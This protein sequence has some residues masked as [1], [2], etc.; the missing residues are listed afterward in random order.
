[1]SNE[2]E[3]IRVYRGEAI[4]VIDDLTTVQELLSL[5]NI[6][7]F[8]SYDITKALGTKLGFGS[9]NNALPAGSMPLGQAV[10]TIKTK[11]NKIKAKYI[12][13]F[14]EELAPLS[15]SKL[16]SFKCLPTAGLLNNM[17]LV[18]GVSK[19]LE[20]MKQKQDSINSKIDEMNKKAN[21]TQLNGSALS[22]FYTIANARILDSY[23]KEQQLVDDFTRKQKEKADKVKN[24]Y[25]RYVEATLNNMPMDSSVPLG[26]NTI[27]LGLT[28]VPVDPV[29]SALANF[30]MFLL[31]CQA[32]KSTQLCSNKN[33]PLTRE[34]LTSSRV[35]GASLS[36]DASNAASN[37]KS[38][39]IEGAVELQSPSFKA[40]EARFNHA[41]SFGFR[42][43]GKRS[44]YQ[45]QYASI[46]RSIGNSRSV[47][48]VEA[49]VNEIEKLI[50]RIEAS[51]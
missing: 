36:N 30:N 26:L 24:D 38:K 13:T 2:R 3:A 31:S 34:S 46:I 35:T 5:Y 28:P 16:E 18:D 25:S 32:P 47:G 12:N 45:T 14:P 37:K 44:Y 21:D 41:M 42:D 6:T 29:S 17:D 4:K 23:T 50:A 40:L 1:M 49:Y 8:S 7:S 20:A 43:P 48:D 39:V 15:R 11:I 19:S 9:D 33:K 51:A 27:A 10:F 22:T